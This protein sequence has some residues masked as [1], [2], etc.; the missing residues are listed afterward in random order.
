MG[1]RADEVLLPGPVTAQDFFILELGGPLVPA[2]Y[3]PTSVSPSSILWTTDSNSLVLDSEF[4]PG[5]RIE[6]R[7][8][9]PRPSVD[10]LRSTTVNNA[11]AVYYELPGGFPDV[12]RETA[13]FVTRDAATAFDALIALQTW[14]RTEFDYNIDVQSGSSNDAIES[15]LRTKEGF[16]QQ[17]AGTF[18]A[19][20]RSLGI[21]ARVAVGFTEGALEADGR[22]HVF[23]RNAHAWP[24]TWFDDVGWVA[25]EPT[26][27]R[28]SGDSTAYTGVD[29]AQDTTSGGGGGSGDGAGDAGAQTSVPLVTSG[30]EDG[31]ETGDTTGG[32]SVTTTPTG[33]ASGGG[34]GDGSTS[35]VPFVL[36]GAIV[37]LSAWVVFAPRV[38]RARA[39]HHASNPPE[40]VIGAWHRSL[41]S[42][43]L[44]GAPTPAGATPLE[45][46]A[47]AE[48]ATGI[49]HH[50]LREMATHVTRAVYS[51]GEITEATA[52]RCETLSREVGIICRDR[53]PTAL[54]LRALIDPRLMRLRYSG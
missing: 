41:G 5:D 51:R 45:Y 54:R 23:G 6:I 10:L 42:L 21:P 28:G 8:M 49:D 22:Y 46:A 3:V 14:F 20:A 37:L 35:L 44:A 29:A 12:A 26:P 7:S 53:T 24:E 4:G 32:T 33:P 50:V 43:L 52:V 1:N 15:F 17:F 31:R 25:F 19:M 11:P 47:V 34:R 48:L 30:I 2:A 36:L 9:V 27:G 16:C 38:V 39:A 13:A 40:R 18:A